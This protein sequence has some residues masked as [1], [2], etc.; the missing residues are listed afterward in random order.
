VISQGRYLLAIESAIAGGSIAILDDSEVMAARCGDGSVSRAEDL[1]PNIAAML[2]DAGISKNE[3]WRVAVSL[4]PG[5]Y[6]GL[7]IG[8]ATVMGLRRG[9]HIEYVGV[10]LFDALAGQYPDSLIAVPM[11]KADICSADS[12]SLREPRVV[13]TEKFTE[14]ARSREARNIVVHPGLTD[15]LDRIPGIEILD[16][17]LATYIGRAALILPLSD[18][19]D[20]IYVQNPRFG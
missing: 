18:R 13:N 14:M 20:P 16:P 3:L 7:R 2:E 19:L 8:I 1:L 9:L 10:P 4:G 15:Q 11:G 17:N 12:R 5:S 6:T